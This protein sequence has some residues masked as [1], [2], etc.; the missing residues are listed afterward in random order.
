VLLNE[1]LHMLMMTCKKKY[2]VEVINLGL[3]MFQKTRD[4]KCEVPYRLLQEGLEILL[5]H[6]D[7]T[8]QVEVSDAF[9]K[10]LASINDHSINF[11]DI[12]SK[13]STALSNKFTSMKK[14][15][16]VMRFGKASQGGE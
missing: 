15:S 9:F 11:A 3:K 6:M 10:D 2:K 14:G 16:A 5:P 7:Y 12:A 4:D 8:R 13:H 1:G